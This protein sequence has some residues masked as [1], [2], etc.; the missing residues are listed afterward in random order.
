MKKVLFGISLLVCFCLN[1]KA[2][3]TIRFENGKERDIVGLVDVMD[4]SNRK[5]GFIQNGKLSIKLD[6]TKKSVVVF[7]Y[8]GELYFLFGEPNKE[9]SFDC[10]TRK[11]VGENDNIMTFLDKWKKNYFEVPDNILE[12]SLRSLVLQKSKKDKN[13]TPELLVSPD[14]LRSLQKSKKEQL[15]ILRKHK[16]KNKD[17]SRLFSEYI[18]AYYWESVITAAKLVRYKY[19]DVPD[20]LLEEI[21]NLDVNNPELKEKDYA[22]SWLDAYVKA[23]EDK[24][25][26][27]QTLNEYVYKTAMFIKNKQIR[28]FY[29]LNKLEKTVK[30]KDFVCFEELFANSTSCIVSNEG[31]Q[32]FKRLY[33]EGK[34]MSLNGFNGVKAKELT[35]FTS[36]GKEAKLSDY[37]GKYVY[38]DIWATWC[39]PCKQEAPNFMRL[40]ERMQGKDIVF[41]SLSAD[42][43]KDKETWNN[44][45]REHSVDKY[46]VAGWTG[47]GF[48]SSFIAHYGIKSIPRF[49]LVGPDG[50]MIYQNCWRPSNVLIDELL[51]SFLK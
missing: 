5:L 9:Y 18:N 11:F 38:I 20:V 2:Q 48:R 32:M 15:K 10:L 51:N 39:S 42:K 26:L 29:I 1:T 21:L 50:N 44:Y 13:I 27:K 49:M 7:G 14:F 16:L 3:L 30:K 6:I 19:M 35:F 17:F 47:C 25:I 43:I 41:L 37:V 22:E 4:E 23:L 28:E 31:K 36:E 33:D 12:N 34:S 46:C 40:A 24:G 45:V 8:K